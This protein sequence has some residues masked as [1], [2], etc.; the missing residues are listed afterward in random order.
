MLLEKSPS[1]MGRFIHEL[2]PSLLNTLTDKADEVVLMNLQVGL[3]RGRG[4]KGIGREG[5]KGIG[6]EGSSFE[7]Q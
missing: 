2:L 1:D 6:G 7:R 3:G 4:E 5:G